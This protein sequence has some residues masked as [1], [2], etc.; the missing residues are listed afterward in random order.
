MRDPFDYNN[1]QDAV[2]FKSL[3]GVFNNNS[4]VLCEKSGR[5]TSNSTCVYVCVFFVVVE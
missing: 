5:Q 4:I 2:N 1:K 3:D